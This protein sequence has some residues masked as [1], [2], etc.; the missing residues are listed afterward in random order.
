VGEKNEQI[1]FKSIRH[2]MEMALISF[3]PSRKRLGILQRLELLT[4]ALSQLKSNMGD[5]KA[6]RKMEVWAIRKI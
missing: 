6:D 1:W 4:N 3:P 5:L 2:N